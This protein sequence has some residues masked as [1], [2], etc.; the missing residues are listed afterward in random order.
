VLAVGQEVEVQVLDIKPDAK[1]RSASRSS[2]RALVRD[3]WHDEAA[4][5]T[6]G[7]RRSG[8]VARIEN[9]GAFVELAPG[10]DGLLHVSELGANKPIRH[11]R[12]AVKVGQTVEVTVKSVDHER[13]RVSLRAGSGRGGGNAGGREG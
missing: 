5:L 4:K 6:P 11:P 3:P 10:V 9:F 7:T 1:G 12:E 8:R 2:R 13:R